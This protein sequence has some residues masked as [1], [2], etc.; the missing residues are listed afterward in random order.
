MEYLERQEDAGGVVGLIGGSSDWFKV[1]ILVFRI[2]CSVEAHKFRLPTRDPLISRL[3]LVIFYQISP[4][5]NKSYF[6]IKLSSYCCNLCHEV[7]FPTYPLPLTPSSSTYIS[8]D[9]ISEHLSHSCPPNHNIYLNV[10]ALITFFKI[11]SSIP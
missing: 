2:P 5:I 8:T 10:D 3:T 6:C 9:L 7:H 11:L 4:Y 1:C